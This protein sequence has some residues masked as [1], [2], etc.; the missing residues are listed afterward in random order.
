M[1]LC[2]LFFVNRMLSGNRVILFD[3]NFALNGLLV[4]ARIISVALA[5]TL[6]IPDGDEFDQMDL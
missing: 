3:F 2:F 5:D 1:F 6:G 4:L